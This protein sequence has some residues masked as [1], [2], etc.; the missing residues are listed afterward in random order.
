MPSVLKLRPLW[1]SGVAKPVTG[2]KSCNGCTTGTRR[3]ALESSSC[4]ILQEGF[5][6]SVYSKY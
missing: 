6:L 4:F 2:V 1:E 5:A 3:F